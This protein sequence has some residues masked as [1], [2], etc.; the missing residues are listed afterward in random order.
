[1]KG[2]AVLV[3]AVSGKD[4][5]DRERREITGKVGQ[6]AQ[7]SFS[8][9]G[10]RPTLSPDRRAIKESIDDRARTPPPPVDM[11]KVDTK[12][13]IP[14]GLMIAEGVRPIVVI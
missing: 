1:M 13:V 11:R 12:V 5:R 4:D 10:G 9:Y 6:K 3:A 2:L 8:A 7:E 14:P